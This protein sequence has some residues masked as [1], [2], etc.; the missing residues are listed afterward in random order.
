[1]QHRRHC[2]ALPRGIGGQLSG[3]LDPQKATIRTITSPHEVQSTFQMAQFNAQYSALHRAV[4]HVRSGFQVPTGAHTSGSRRRRACTRTLMLKKKLGYLGA[5]LNGS[6]TV[7]SGGW[8]VTVGGWRVT[9]GGWR[10]TH[11]VWGV[12]AGGWRGTVG[13]CRVTDGN[14]GGR[15]LTKKIFPS[16]PGLHWGAVGVV[17]CAAGSAGCSRL[18]RRLQCRGPRGPLEGVPSGGGCQAAQLP[19][20]PAFL[21]R[22]RPPPGRHLGN[23]RYP[24]RAVRLPKRSPNPRVGPTWCVSKPQEVT[25]CSPF[26]EAVHDCLRWRQSSP[27]SRLSYWRRRPLATPP[28][29][30]CHSVLP[31]LRHPELSR[32]KLRPV[33]D[34]VGS[35]SCRAPSDPEDTGGTPA[36]LLSA[37]TPAFVG[38]G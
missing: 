10:I 15:F 20:V 1:M 4:G 36:S 28:R 13:W 21:W 23:Q 17:V 5:Q 30:M 38:E 27:C 14:G 26:P 16:C 7:N 3:N 22:Q 25:I 11:G 31:L 24:L 34:S 8:R 12:T 37:V 35:S 9:D 2:V 29:A 32:N 19:P 33:T 18:S 6:C